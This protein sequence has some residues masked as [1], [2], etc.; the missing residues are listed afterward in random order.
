MIHS[1]RRKTRQISLGG[2][3]IGG[4]APVTVQSM[5][6]CH[7]W[8]IEKAKD[9]IQKLESA[10]VDIIR[11]A[12]PDMDSAKVFGKLK[13]ESRVPLVADIHFDHKLAIA[14][15]ENGA[16]C[17][18]INPGN[19]S[20]GDKLK[21]V[22]EAAKKAKIP[23]RIGINSGSIRSGLR[24]KY[25][26]DQISA[27]GESLVE[28]LKP[29]EEEDFTDI[30]I[31][32][33]S[34]DAFET[35]SIYRKISNLTDYPLHLGVTAA[36]SYANSIVKSSIGIGTLLCEG[37]G[38]TIRVSMTGDP[39]Q[40]VVTGKKILK[41]LNLIED[42]V[43][44]IISCPTCG[45]CGV[46]LV[47]IVQEVEDSFASKKGNMTIAVMGCEVNGPKEAQDADLGLTF[48]KDLGIIFIKG[49]V[50]NRI[51]RSESVDALIRAYE[52]LMNRK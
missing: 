36:G 44:Q 51:S 28:A 3:K 18:R 48:S 4:G 49:K 21:K 16:D 45:R 10:G 5:L 26:D 29:F 23:I 47:K 32:A 14:S 11:V 52:S 9:A 7:S 38:D 50:S 20:G 22:I 34:S 1:I 35:I 13:S 24:K 30:K 19:M 12:I 33:K 17:I 43:P 2:I 6:K 27:M 8:D 40:E 46:D 31:S 42:N 41:S 37:I 25:P 39:V 15:I